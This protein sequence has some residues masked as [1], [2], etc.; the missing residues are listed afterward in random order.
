MTF[1]LK[2]CYI[3]NENPKTVKYKKA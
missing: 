1:E 3:G 2:R